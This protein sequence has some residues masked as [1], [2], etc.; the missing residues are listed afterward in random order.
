MLCVRACRVWYN[1]AGE[2]QCGDFDI[3]LDLGLGNLDELSCS[4]CCKFEKTERNRITKTKESNK[5]GAGSRKTTKRSL[6]GF[7]STLSSLFC[8]LFCVQPDV[9][10]KNR[11]RKTKK[12]IFP[13]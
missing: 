8:T 1:A 2:S 12:K 5:V 3:D 11:E 4:F 10:L 7:L 9:F 13:V 6:Q